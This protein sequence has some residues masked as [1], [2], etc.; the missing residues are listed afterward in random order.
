MADI[1]TINGELVRY[2]ADLMAL[3]QI[4]A[5]NKYDVASEDADFSALKA[6]AKEKKTA[7]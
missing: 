3:P 5:A 7:T 2:N 6:Y 1:E 4:I